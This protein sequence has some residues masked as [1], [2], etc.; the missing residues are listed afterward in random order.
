MWW[1]M[2]K[3]TEA[4]TCPVISVFGRLR[5]EEDFKASLGYIYIV[6][7]SRKGAHILQISVTCLCPLLGT[8]AGLWSPPVGIVC[9][10]LLTAPPQAFPV[11]IGTETPS[12][13]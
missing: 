3:N 13:G 12:S 8:L 4:G 10:K 6:Q 7:Q 2:F 5:Q 1:C 9:Y 11:G